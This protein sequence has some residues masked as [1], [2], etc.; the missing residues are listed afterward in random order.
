MGFFVASNSDFKKGR[1][2]QLRDWLNKNS[3]LVTVGAIVVLCLAL[4][5]VFM[6]GGGGDSVASYSNSHYFLDEGT[7]KLFAAPVESVAPIEAPSNKGKKGKPAGVRARIFVC[8]K[9]DPGDMVGLT[10]AEAEEKGAFVAYLEKF[11]SDVA[12]QLR[13]DLEGGMSLSNVAGNGAMLVKKPSQKRWLSV[14]V[15]S[16]QKL[17][18]SPFFACGEGMPSE[19]FPPK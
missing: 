4:G 9:I 8:D 6:K 18:A 17:K 5:Y 10:V 7:G 13:A 16:G 12:K 14:G 19:V 1:F 2:M 11:P 3:T 15:P